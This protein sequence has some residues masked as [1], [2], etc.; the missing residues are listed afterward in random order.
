MKRFHCG[1]LV[2]LIALWATIPAFADDN[3]RSLYDKGQKAEARQ[4]YEEAYHVFQA[5]LRPASGKYRLPRRL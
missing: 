5:G 4:Q 3:A 2:L 1:Y